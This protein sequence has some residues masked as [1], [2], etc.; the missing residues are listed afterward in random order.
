M[1]FHG[2]NSLRFFVDFRPEVHDSDGMLLSFV[3]GEWLWRPI[4]N[5]ETLQVSSYRLANP[6]GFGL[7]QRDRDFDHY[8]DIETRSEIRPS[9]WIT[10]KGEWGAGTMELIEIPAKNEVN[11]NIVSYWVPEKKPKPGEPMTFAYDIQWYADEKDRPP[12][13][14]VMATRRDRGT[15]PDGHRFIIDF[16]GGKLGGLAADTVV[17]GVVSVSS[18]TEIGDELLEQHVV[19]NPATGGWRLGF[20]VK[21]KSNDPLDLRAFLQKGDDVLTETWSYTLRP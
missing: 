15:H 2:E 20:Q 11:D 18:G 7:L 4:D 19:K 16:E 21:P 1:M 9:G 6:R 12:G 5:P 3:T 17:R 14:R 13:G 10:P 8:Q